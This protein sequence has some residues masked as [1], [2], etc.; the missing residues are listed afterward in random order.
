MDDSRLMRALALDDS[1]HVIRVLAEGPSGRT[2]LVTLKSEDDTLLVRKRIPDALANARAWASVVGIDDPL[3]PH[4][5][6]IYRMPD[7]LV[8]VYGYV[9]GRSLYEVITGEGSFDV[10]RAANVTIDVCHAAA[11][12]HDVGVVHRDITP[13][14]VILSDDGAHLVDLGIARVGEPD[15][16]R[17][18]NM[19]GTWGFI[20]PEQLG[21]AQTD[22]RSDVFS[23]GCLLG[24]MLTGFEPDK[25][26]YQILLE[27]DSCVPFGLK[28]VINKACALEPS[29][30]YQSAR[31]LGEA[32]RM[33]AANKDLSPDRGAAYEQVQVQEDESDRQE[34]VAGEQRTD[35]AEFSDA[36][37]GSPSTFSLPRVGDVYTHSAERAEAEN[38]A[39]WAATNER[40]ARQEES[41]ETRSQTSR[42]PNVGYGAPPMPQGASAPGAGWQ[43]APRVQDNVHWQDAQVVPQY[44]SGIRAYVR[45]WLALPVLSKVMDVLTWSITVLGVIVFANN[46]SNNQGAKLISWLAMD[47]WAIVWSVY[48]AF[49]S[50][51]RTMEERIYRFARIPLGL[52]RWFG[53]LVVGLFL[54][55]LFRVALFPDPE[56]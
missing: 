45:S 56:V 44:D 50:H 5:E 30:R 34:R 14:N 9:E 16:A 6:N 17:D 51:R 8:V 27:D 41:W 7:E 35:D 24:Y 36:A 3:V 54:I 37:S 39:S 42:R 19:L 40:D 32:V 13:G 4:V 43:D 52:L 21:Y 46:T 47:A 29:K 25:A 26:S 48:A 18:T 2:E 11:V 28:R 15:R 38:Y 20:A 31:E 23:I 1:Y 53:I 10:A 22:A 12:L 33:A 55:A 49:L